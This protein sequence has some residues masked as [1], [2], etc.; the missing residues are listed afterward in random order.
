MVL[1]LKLYFIASKKFS[2]YTELLHKK[3]MFT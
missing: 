1:E 3:L 2:V